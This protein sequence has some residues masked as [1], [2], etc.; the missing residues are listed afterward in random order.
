MFNWFKKK[1]FPCPCCGTWAFFVDG[2]Y[3][4]CEVCNWE[5]DPVQLENPDLEGGANKL[6][7]NQARLK[8]TN[9]TS[10]NQHRTK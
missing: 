8:F 5:N 9:E 6:S 1:I 10:I 7:L 3:S 4:I 2:D